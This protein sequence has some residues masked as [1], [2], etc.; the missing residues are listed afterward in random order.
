MRNR[1]AIPRRV[2]PETN[3]LKRYCPIGDDEGEVAKQGEW[4]WAYFSDE[5]GGSTKQTFLPFLMRNMRAIP[6]WIRAKTNYLKRYCP[7]RR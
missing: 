5:N 7:R 3:Y 4:L 6:W 1:R 2:W